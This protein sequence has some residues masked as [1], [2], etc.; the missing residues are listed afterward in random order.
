[1]RLRGGG[2]MHSDTAHRGRLL[3][4]ALGFLG[5]DVAPPAM[6]PGL[7]APHAGLDTWHD[8][9]LIERDGAGGP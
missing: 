9:G 7:R 6:L 4:I 5:L 2:L 8:I 1:M 3:Y